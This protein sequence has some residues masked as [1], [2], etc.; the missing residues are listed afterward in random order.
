MGKS[1]RHTQTYTHTHTHSHNHENTKEYSRYVRK[2]QLNKFSQLL[3]KENRKQTPQN[4]GNGIFSITLVLLSIIT[5]TGMTTFLSRRLKGLGR[6]WKIYHDHILTAIE[7]SDF[8]VFK[9]SNPHS[10]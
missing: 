5:C 9:V 10:F 4:R 2:L 3:E 7:V 1:S 8:K 6:K